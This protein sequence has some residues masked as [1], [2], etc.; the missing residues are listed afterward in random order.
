[1][2]QVLAVNAGGMSA[3]TCQS[4]QI[5]VPSKRSYPFRKEV[6]TGRKK[7]KTDSYVVVRIYEQRKDLEHTDEIECALTPDGELDLA[8]LSERLN[9]KW[10]QVSRLLIP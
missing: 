6:P 2:E 1:M 9:V 8:G 3:P 7:R 5:V 10:C 4:S